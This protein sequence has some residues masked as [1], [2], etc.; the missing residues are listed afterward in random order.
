MRHIVTRSLHAVS[1]ILSLNEAEQLILNLT[2]SIAETKIII[3]KNSEIESQ[4]LLQIDVRIVRLEYLRTVRV[5]E[6]VFMKEE[7]MKKK[8]GCENNVTIQGVE[9]MIKD[10]AKEINLF[11]QTIKTEKDA[12]KPEDIFPLVGSVYRLPING[13][14]QS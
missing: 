14:K 4:C 7:Q 3:L 8:S 6:K 11:K 12:L 9:Q 5:N 1:K 10:Y 2:R 13:K